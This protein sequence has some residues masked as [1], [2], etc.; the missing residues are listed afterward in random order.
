[1]IKKSIFITKSKIVRIWPELILNSVQN[2]I[3][4]ERKILVHA[5]IAATALQF[6]H[7]PQLKALS[8]VK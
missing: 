4:T 8:L 3:N 6:A 1:M 5:L 7:F 2:F